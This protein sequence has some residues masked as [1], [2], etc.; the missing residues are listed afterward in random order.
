MG[1]YDLSRRQKRLLVRGRLSEPG[2]AAMSDRAIARELGVSQPFV[3]AQR[4]LVSRRC[5]T[6]RQPRNE[7]I[8]SCHDD[9]ENAGLLE[10]PGGLGVI[11]RAWP[12]PREGSSYERQD[13][14]NGFLDNTPRATW[15]SRHRWSVEEGRSRTVPDGESFD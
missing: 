9:A 1:I 7:D 10:P 6:D 4:R 2:A 8:P 12:E 14:F 15:V 5:D 11:E 13:R 3:S